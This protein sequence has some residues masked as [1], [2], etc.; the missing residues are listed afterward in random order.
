METS[1]KLM[2]VWEFCLES[3]H[4]G[5]ESYRILKVVEEKLARLGVNPLSCDFEPIPAVLTKLYQL[6]F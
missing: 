2:T 5:N 3:A 4:V 6:N 1:S